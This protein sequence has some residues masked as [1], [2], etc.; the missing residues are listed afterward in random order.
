VTAVTGT[1]RFLD[2]QTVVLDRNDEKVGQVS[3]HFP[4]VGY[5]I[6]RV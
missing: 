5:E 1:L 4:R 3:V 6:Q 2:A